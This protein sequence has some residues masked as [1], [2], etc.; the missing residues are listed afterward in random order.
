ME[1]Q[2][3]LH[4]KTK[5]LLRTAEQQVTS[6]RQQ[7]NSENLGT[8]PKQPVRTLPKGKQKLEDGVVSVIISSA[9]KDNIVPVMCSF[10]SW[11]SSAG[12]R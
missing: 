4:Q 5:E 6:M 12:G 3:A 1:A 2:T 9:I 8:A 7:L 11:R 10:S